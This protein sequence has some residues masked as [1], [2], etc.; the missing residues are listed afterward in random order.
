MVNLSV[1]FMLS[2]HA[3]SSIFSQT[4]S[5]PPSVSSV[6][7]DLSS[8]TEEIRQKIAI[9]TNNSLSISLCSFTK[10]HYAQM[11]PLQTVPNM[12]DVLAHILRMSLEKEESTKQEKEESARQEESARNAILALCLQKS[13]KISDLLNSASSSRHFALTP[14]ESSFSDTQ[15]LLLS[16]FPE[17]GNAL[18]NFNLLLASLAEAKA[19][20]REARFLLFRQWVTDFGSQNQKL[21]FA[22]D[23]LPQKE[24]QALV[25]D[26]FLEN[27]SKWP[28]YVPLSAPECEC[29]YGDNEECEA[30][31]EVSRA[32]E[33]SSEEFESLRVLRSLLPSLPNVSATANI[34][35]HSVSRSSCDSRDSRKSIHVT[36]SF[37]GAISF[38]RKFAIPR[39]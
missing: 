28:R 12:D 25:L 3:R 7:I 17:G 22:E 15:L 34:F 1:H 39:P 38:T 2:E 32:E 9:S 21:R 35:L 10:E 14:S 24:I 18:N 8:L 19:K 13:S 6:D 11:T 33:A 30:V 26:H 29:V 5:M 16:S 23:L 20:K 31:F 37:N 36:S 4:G 27:L